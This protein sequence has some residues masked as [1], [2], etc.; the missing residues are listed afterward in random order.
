MPKMS[1]GVWA[2]CLL[3]VGLGLIALPAD[4]RGFRVGQTPN[5]S[6]FSCGLCHINPNGGGARNL[7]GGDVELSLSDGDVNWA[8]IYN[9]DPDGDGY[10]N[11]EELGDPEGTWL[12][13]DPQP[14][15]APSDPNDPRSFP[16]PCGNGV[17]ELG[18]QCEVGDLDGADCLSLGFLGGD[19]GCSIQCTFDTHDCNNCGN[20]FVEGREECDGPDLGEASCVTL[21]FGSGDLTCTPG[22]TLDASACSD[23]GDGVR[24]GGERCDG[25]DL[26]GQTCI[27]LGYQGGEIACTDDC[28]LSTDPCEGDPALVCGDGVKSADE[29]CDG[30]DLGG[31]SCESL[32]HAGGSLACRVD[33]TLNVAG[34]ET[35]TPGPDAGPD[36]VRD[37]DAGSDAVAEPDMDDTLDAGFDVAPPAGGGSSGTGCGVASRPGHF[38]WIFT[39]GR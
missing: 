37:P 6:G 3:A 20:D 28:R 31:E 7:F 5:G 22:C 26:D 27:S 10:T 11:G 18:E 9:L 36:V 17:L 1:P 33:C 19:L 23:C 21:G 15:V 25:D 13:G 32:G 14:R 16:Q 39:R 30:D 24:D 34:C 4:A 8:A 35:S 12:I 38:H 2:P 29:S